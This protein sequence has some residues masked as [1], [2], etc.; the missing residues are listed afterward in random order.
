MK[1]P[2]TEDVLHGVKMAFSTEGLNLLLNQWGF[3]LQMTR[4]KVQM[5][6][7]KSAGTSHGAVG[8]VCVSGD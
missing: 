7:L 5:N 1:G 4:C 8:F 6:L 2:L 3:G